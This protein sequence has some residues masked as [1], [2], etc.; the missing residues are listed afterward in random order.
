MENLFIHLIWDG[1]YN[2]DSIKNLKNLSEDRGLYQIYGQHS[3]YGHSVLIYI[4]KAEDQTFSKRITQE[5]WSYWHDDSKNIEI[6]VGRV[7]DKISVESEEIKRRISISEK[8]LIFAHC[9]VYNTS[10]SKGVYRDV[11]KEY[12]VLNWGKKRDI[13]PE[14]SAMRFSCH[15]EYI[16]EY[17]PLIFA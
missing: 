9:P 1:P 7:A 4:G 15:N 14:V 8:L 3:L 13:F 12:H 5:D 16:S 11:E 2:L 10:N 6:Y 17:K